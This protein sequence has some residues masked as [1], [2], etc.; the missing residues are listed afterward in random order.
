M[1]CSD[2]I[3]KLDRK[4]GR[5]CKTSFSKS[6]EQ[7]HTV[8]LQRDYYTLKFKNNQSTVVPVKYNLILLSVEKKMLTLL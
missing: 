4:N 6:N 8:G 3:K 1:Y 5:A 7:A 2:E